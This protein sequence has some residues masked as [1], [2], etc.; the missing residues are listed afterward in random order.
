MQSR[1]IP[2]FAFTNAKEA[3]AYY[4]RVFGATDVY[5]FSPQPEQAKQFHLPEGADLESMTIH[6]GFT[7]LGMSFQCADSFRGPVK[8]SNQVDII[9]DIDGDDA[10]SVS[11]AEAFYDKLAASGEVTIDMPFETQ[12]WGGKM[13][14]FTDKYGISWMLHMIPWSQIKDPTK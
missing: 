5:R 13:G 2:S 4:Q 9:L 6:G 7:V 8:P 11:A 3:L 14:H 12:F 10:S 1:I